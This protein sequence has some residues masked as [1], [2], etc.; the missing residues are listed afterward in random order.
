MVKRAWEVH[1]MDGHRQRESF[2][3]DIFVEQIEDEREVADFT[4]A[5]L[6][7][8]D[9]TITPAYEFDY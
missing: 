1:G 8:A 4:D 5:I 7:A 2:N 3:Y 9:N 6:A